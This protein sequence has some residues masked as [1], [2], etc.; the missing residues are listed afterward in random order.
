MVLI[1]YL[2]LCAQHRNRKWPLKTLFLR[3]DELGLLSLCRISPPLNI[4]ATNPNNVISR[5]L[6]GI[7]NNIILDF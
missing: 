2:V 3:W 6:L 5:F 4:T 1:S 7:R